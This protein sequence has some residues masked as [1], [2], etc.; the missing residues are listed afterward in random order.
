MQ[1]AAQEG[2]GAGAL[3]TIHHLPRSVLPLSLGA[4]FVYVTSVGLATHA[5]FP[6]D[7]S[8]AGGTEARARRLVSS[9]GR[10][11]LLYAAACAV[12]HA[13]AAAYL[14]FAGTD[15]TALAMQRVLWYLPFLAACRIAAGLAA[16]LRLR[17]L[18]LAPAA[19]ALHVLCRGRPPLGAPFD[20][21]GFLLGEIQT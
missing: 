10:L 6:Q 2:P 19:A 21:V 7:Q 1:R 14:E 13:I 12:A 3:V 5:L 20:L 8:G 18:P 11:L 4:A 15:C 16:L 9:A 17:R